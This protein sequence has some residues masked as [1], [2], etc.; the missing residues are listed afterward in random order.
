MSNSAGLFKARQFGTESTTRKSFLADSTLDFLSPHQTAASTFARAELTKNDKYCVSRLPAIPPILNHDHVANDSGLLNGYAD[1]KTDFALVVSE[2]TINV[3]R[4]NSSDDVPISFEFPLGESAQDAFQL[5]IL[6]RSSPGTSLD[7]GLVIINSTSGHILF[8]ESV[9]QAPALGM[10]NS[11]SIETQINLLAHQGEYIT[12]AE[13]V[14]PAG[15]VVATSWKRVVLVL[16]RDHKGTPK[17]SSLELTKPST[18]SRF[19]GSWIG[20]NDDEITDEIVSLK[21]G[22]TSNQGTTQ[23]II[24][25][26]ASGTFKRYVY[27]AS[28]TGAPYINYKKTLLFRLASY[29]ES[30]IDGFIPGSVVNVKFLDLWPAF[31]K[32]LNSDANDLFIALV[33]VQSSLQ[34]SNEERLAL[35]TMKI[36]ESGVMITR[37]HLLPEVYT[38]H[39][40][41][42]V[43]KPKLF[44]PKPGTSAF[45][46]IGPAVVLCDLSSETARASEFFYYKPKWED[47]IKFKADMQMI[48]FGYEDQSKK[49]ENPALLIITSDFGVLRIERFV[50][51]DADHYSSDEDFNPVNLLKSHIQQAIYFSDSPVMDFNVGSNYP[52]NVIVDA[53]SQINSE[54]LECSSPYL[55]PYFSST[56]DSFSLRLK[57]LHNLIAFFK[58]NFDS[59]WDTVYPF[60]VEALEKIQVALNLWNLIDTEGSEAK[61][62]K[63]AVKEILVAASLVPNNG[64]DALR[65]YFEKDVTGILDVLTSLFNGSL[66]ISVPSK[67][68]LDVLLVTLHDA[69]Y[70][71]E[72]THI[73]PYG[74]IPVRRSWVFD[75]N[76]IVKA[77]DLVS[78]SF[79]SQVESSLHN[80]KSRDEFVKLVATLYHLMS[81]A[82]KYMSVHNDEQLSEYTEWFKR[83]RTDWIQAFLANGILREALIIAEQY[84]D[85]SS[86]SRILEKE[87]DLCSPEYILD[88][89]AFYMNEYGYEFACELFNFEVELDHI[90]RLLME[91]SDYD[92]FLT[93]YFDDHQQETGSFSWIYNVK[94]NAYDFA[95]KTLISLSNSKT[96]DNQQNREFG[97]SMAKLSALASEYEESNTMGSFATEELII[98]AENSLVVVRIQNKL[99]NY[100]SRFVEGKKQIISLDYFFD[101]FVNAKL[102]RSQLTPELK[103]FFQ[104]FVNQKA[105][106]QKQLVSLLTS[107]NPIAELRAVYTDALI[108]AALISNDQ[109]FRSL[110][111]EIWVKLLAYTDDWN[112]IAETGDNTDEVNKTKLRETILYR[113]LKD[114]KGNKD[115][116]GALDWVLNEPGVSS[117]GKAPHLKRVHELNEKFNIKKWVTIIQTEA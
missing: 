114:V 6:T 75:S 86:I 51:S 38:A 104:D 68:L 110:A 87:R 61:I 33:C 66:K 74:Q 93:K 23:E 48:G 52:D 64:G 76:L 95:S 28:S 80:S 17:L 44:I 4:Y 65:S 25:Q 71:N 12:L 16:L 63:S 2:K 45:V 69:V 99:Y 82:I 59:C 97:F 8:F 26:D 77:E 41:S 19:F 62:L 58:Q 30:N 117:D 72:L 7:P 49:D 13:N 107:I 54:I 24:V 113:T 35:L 14:E 27:Q 50:G 88:K 116:M 43:S 9:Q 10:I 101:N 85:Y 1:G 47:T 46:V 32:D 91:Y 109:A 11:K 81:S 115:I 84:K 105:L 83:R 100:I 22:R 55:P 108:V 57:L 92:E 67:S 40:H 60:I 20:S 3:W 89:I 94:S 36:N 96:F 102:S 42:L 70:V 18:S 39:N 15:I 78:R 79:C 53:I 103:P 37:S 5:A 56:R 21:A 112:L 29:L 31:S 34:G 73:V 111:S 98:E 106:S 90:Q